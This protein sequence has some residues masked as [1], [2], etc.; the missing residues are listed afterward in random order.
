[1]TVNWSKRINSDIEY[2]VRKKKYRKIFD[3]LE[4]V[5]EELEKGKLVGDKLESLGLSEGTAAY[6]VRIAN[7]SANIANIIG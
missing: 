2:Y 5:L 6:K 1:M 4:P 7:S 3:D